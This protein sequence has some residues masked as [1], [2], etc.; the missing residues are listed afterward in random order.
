MKTPLKIEFQNHSEAVLKKTLL[1]VSPEEGC[2]L[3]VGKEKQLKLNRKEIS[4][5]ISL[6]WPCCNIWKPGKTWFQESNP[7]NKKSKEIPSKKNRFTIDHNEQLIAQK[8]ARER[9]LSILGSAHS[10]LSNFSIPSAIDLEWNF[11]TSLMMIV[12]KDGLLR[13]WWIKNSSV[14]ETIEVPYTA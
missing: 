7:K 2:A 4:Y 10:H 14:Q 9:K 8:W 1:A 13:A 3:L 12:N 5:Q 11:S 6:I